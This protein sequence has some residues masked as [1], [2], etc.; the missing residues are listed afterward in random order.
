MML[1]FL[2]AV[3]PARAQTQVVQKFD[4]TAPA[5]TPVFTVGDKWEVVWDSPAPLRITLLSSDGT[6][7]AGTTGVFRG[8]FYQPKG[9]SFYLQVDGSGNGVMPPWHLAVQE[10]AGDASPTNSV[11][12]AGP[13]MHFVPPSVQPPAA[14]AAASTNTV[15]STP[16]P[17]APAPPPPPVVNLTEDQTRAVVM[18]EGDNTE[19]TGFL[20]KMPDGP[21]VVT[22][23]HVLASNPNVRI[24]TNTGAQ[25]TTLGMKG[26]SDRDLALLAIKDDHYSYLD[27]DANLSGDVHPGDD[28]IT[29]GNSQGGEVVLDTHGT[30]V[31]VGPD[32]VEFTNPIY[33]GNSGGPVFH[34]KTGKVL[35]VVTE[36]TKV[37]TSNELDKTSF[38]SRDSAI[39]GSMRYFGLRLDTV[40][41]WETYDPVEFQTETTFLDQ[42]HAQSRRLDSYLNSSARN[43]AQANDADE[44]ARPSSTFYL[45]DDKIVKAHTD[46]M[47]QANGGDGSERLDAF[48][49][50]LFTMDNIADTNL[51]A[52]QNPNN[53]YSFEQQRAR[54]ELAYRQALKKELDSFNDDISRAESLGHHN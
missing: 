34:S 40:P 30:V 19:G 46:F 31:G 33:H 36:A 20:V 23:L 15:A 37:D 8:S 17:P 26:A 28:I 51:A 1:G 2:A 52:I 9:G 7:V 5:T 44:N 48:R 10:V 4:G 32:R 35:G 21:A 45:T 25:I 12:A 53:F 24:L 42:F 13:G 43:D 41:K 47:Q 11:T 16:A 38:G 14:S 6:I 39:T 27:L 50:W 49:A 22:N 29:P 3:I 54:Q 18:I